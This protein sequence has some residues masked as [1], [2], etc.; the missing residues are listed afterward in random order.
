MNEYL[1]L[2]VAIAITGSGVVTGLLFAFSNFVMRALG[3][4]PTEQ[5]ML[6][7]QRI[8]ERIINPIFFIFFMGTPVLCLII[9]V[10]SVLDFGV[11]GYVYF[12]SGAVMYL[13]GPFGITMLFNVPL[14]N[15]L[16]GTAITESAEAWPK[17]IKKWQWWNHVRTYMGIL[18]IL[19]LALGLVMNFGM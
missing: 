1:P 11:S 17:Y 4:L 8:N 15:T 18:S 13:L 9:A 14:N 6:V 10:I 2:I 3:D 7:M 16:A 5:S 12:F 19:L